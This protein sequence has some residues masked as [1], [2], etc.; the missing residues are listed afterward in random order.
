MVIKLHRILALALLCVG[1]LVAGA[2]AVAS[3]PA[4]TPA[5]DCCPNRSHPVGS[6]SFE[7]APHPGLQSCC[8]AGTQTAAAPTSD[9]TP[10]KTEIR[11]TRAD[12]PLSIT[13]FTA[14]SVDYSPVRSGVASARPSFFPALAPLY[15]RT[16]RLRL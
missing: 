12:P 6:C 5:H 15:L 3:C 2:P 11:P 16:R 1:V 4:G 8:A 9:V 13:F 7:I 14:L 10:S